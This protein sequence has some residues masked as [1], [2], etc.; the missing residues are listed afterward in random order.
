MPS[1]IDRVRYPI[2]TAELERRWVKARA[3]MRE[4]KIEA[5]VIQGANNYIGGGGYFRWFSG[6][7]ASNTYPSTLIFPI[8]DLMTLLQG[9]P[10]GGDNTLDGSD[11]AAYG[12]WSVISPMSE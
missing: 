8:D 10:F 3:L 11:P 5:L 4:R 9:G 12:K 7:S 1:L 2:A 6:L